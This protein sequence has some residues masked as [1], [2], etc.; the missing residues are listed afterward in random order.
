[1]RF[2]NALLFVSLAA[3]WGSAFTAIKAGLAFFPPV[4][5]AAFRY[6]LAAVVMLAYAAHATDRWRPRSRAEWTL[7]G[8]GGSLLIAAYHIF[9]FVGE[10]GTTSAAAAIVVS[11]SPILTTGFARA[12]LPDERLTRLGMLG[13]GVGFVGVVVLSKPDP[14]NLLDTRTVSLF[15]IFLAALSF[16]LGSVLTRRVEGELP[17]ETMEAWSMALGA[18]IMHVVSVGLGESAGDVGWT[19]EAVLALLYL[20]VISSALGFLIYFDLL[21]RLG[22]IEINL[23]SYAAPVAAAVTGLALLGETPTVSTAAG[24]GFILLGFLL[25]KRDAIRAEV[26]RFRVY[27]GSGE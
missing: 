7:V 19:G 26:S 9:L 16:G 27:T 17:I 6:D 2:R 4:L 5:F 13:L 1:M 12:F 3:V 8:I 20:S 14:N 24:F 21:E 25:L 11:L 10:Q 22:P 23:V 18:V 15:L